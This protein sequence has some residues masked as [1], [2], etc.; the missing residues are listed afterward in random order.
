MQETRCLLG[1]GPGDAVSLV[2]AAP[3]E[4]DGRLRLFLIEEI[5]SGN[6]KHVPT[7]SLS[8]LRTRDVGSESQ[9]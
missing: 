9:S 5:N 6:A 4:V 3:Y 8:K 2:L 1:L 7:A